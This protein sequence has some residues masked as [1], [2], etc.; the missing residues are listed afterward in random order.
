MNIS[1][2]KEQFSVAYIQAI[3]AQIGLNHSIDAVDDDSVDITLKGKGFTGG[4]LRNPT[5]EIQLKCT[6]QNVIKG[7]VIKFPL[8][9][10]NYD[11]LRGE[12]VGVPRYLMLLVVPDKTENWIHFTNNALIL[13]NNCYWASIRFAPESNNKT[14]VTVE[15]SIEQKVT[16]ESLNR[17]MIMASK[18]EYV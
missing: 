17:L 13:F 1:K 10:K 7:D 2:R 5:I 15:F 6:S 9:L 3:A 4:K 16:T 11:D 12:N 18:E 14:N 8:K